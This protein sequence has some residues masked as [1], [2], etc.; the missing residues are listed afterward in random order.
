MANALDFVLI[1]ENALNVIAAAVTMA[2]AAS[3]S[4]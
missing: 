4:R 1:P 2:T 3:T